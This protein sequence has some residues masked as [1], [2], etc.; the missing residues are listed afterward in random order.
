MIDVAS[1]G[2]LMDK[3]PVAA[4]HL[5][6]NMASNTQQ[7]G[8]RGAITNKAV[9]EVSSV[10]NLRMENQLIELTSLV[11]QLAVETNTANN[12]TKLDILMAATVQ[13]ESRSRAICGP[14]IWT[15]AKHAGSESQL[16]STVGTEISNATIPITTT[17]NTDTEQLTTHGR[18][19]EIPLQLVGTGNL[20]SQP[21]LNPKGGNVS[22]VTL[23]SEA[24][25]RVQ[26]QAK[27]APLLFPSR[28]ISAKKPEID[29][30]L[31]KMFQL[32]EIN[33]PLLDAIKQIPFF[34][35]LEELK[36][37]VEVGGVLLVFIQK[38]VTNGIKPALPRKCRDLR[39]FSVPCTIGSCTFVDAML[40]IR[41]SINVI[42][43]SMY[44]SLN[45]GDL[46]PICGTTCQ[47]SRRCSRPDFY[48]LE[49]EDKTFGKGSTLILGRPFLMTARMKIDVH[50]GTL[51]MEFRDNLVQFNIFYVMR[52]PTE[53]HSLSNMD[54]IDEHVEEYNQ[55]NSGSDNISILVEISNMFEGVGSVMGDAD[56]THI[57]GVLNCPSSSNHLRCITDSLPPQS[58]SDELKPLSDH[59]KYAYLDQDQQFPVIIAN[60]LD[61]EQEEKLLTVLLQH[62][63][64]IEWK[65]SNLPRI[66]CIC[67]HR[68]MMEEEARP[69]QQQ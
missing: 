25:S 44:K 18:M 21:I 15:H 47:H 35:E 38:E 36:G 60:N 2:A 22:V 69:I 56:S 24:D 34:K 50:V 9:N 41:A 3:T 17:T 10:D 4:R 37:G 6:L 8:I 67:M 43:A 51:S 26:Q 1:G 58:P 23:R 7:F 42:F 31:L 13:V 54:V 11:R 62:K 33:I 12:S 20:P 39:I 28:T 5:I 65:L 40:D 14:K 66:N 46:E 49:M 53:D 52:R 48:V 27:I 19:D 55:L 61:Q 45:F 29:E 32:V 59:L 64:S 57:N 30:D 16:L 68:I 63:K